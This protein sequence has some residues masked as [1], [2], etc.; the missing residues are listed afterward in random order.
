MAS[1]TGMHYV[2]GSGPSGIAAATALL[3]RGVPVTMLDV[4]VECE[5][6]RM[7]IVRRMSHQDPSA[8]SEAD[9]RAIASPINNVGR[10]PLKLA[11]GS[12]FAYATDELQAMTQRGT[13]CVMSYAKGGLSNVW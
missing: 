4:G 6:D 11:Y 7:T 2:V 10:F 13:S 3:D 5:P 1:S 12:A 8:W 9:R